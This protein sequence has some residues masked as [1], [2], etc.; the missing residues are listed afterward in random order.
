LAPRLQ[1]VGFVLPEWYVWLPGSRVLIVSSHAAAIAVAVGLAV[2][3][4]GR[5]EGPAMRLVGLTA[6]VGGLVGAHAAFVVERGGTFGAAW[7]GGLSSM[8]GIVAGLSVAAGAARLLGVGVGRAFDAVLPAGLLGLGVGRMGCFLAGCCYGRVADVSWAVVM[9]EVGS[10]P[11]H[12]LQLYSAGVDL[13][14][15]VVA[16]HVGGPPGRRATMA[17]AAFA[18][19]R[20]CLETLRDPGTTTML[21]VVTAPQI[22]CGALLAA[23][24]VAALRQRHV[25]EVD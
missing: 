5:E 18:V 22:V 21:G 17:L 8:G 24:G 10:E 23:M 13:L 16:S 7:G 12:P 11:R 15:F 3:W 4:V 6:A 1:D 9:P 25:R 19:A 20:I 14:L 2:W